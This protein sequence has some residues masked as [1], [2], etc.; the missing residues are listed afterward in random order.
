MTAGHVLLVV[1]AGVFFK[2]DN[3]HKVIFFLVSKQNTASNHLL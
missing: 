3:K 1:T 2:S